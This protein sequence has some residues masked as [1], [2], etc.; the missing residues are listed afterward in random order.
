[1]NN[2]RGEFG[3]F[4]TAILWGLGFV[5]TALG[6]EAFSVIEVLAL[7]FW[8]ASIVLTL[9]FFKHLKKIDK[10]N[11]IYGFVL[12]SFLFFAFYFQTLGLTYT[13]TSKNAFLTSTN[14]VIVPLIGLLFYNR[15]LDI[16]NT[17]GALLTLLGI[18]FISYNP[19]FSINIGDMI[20]LFCAVLFAFHIFYTSEFN[21]R[22][23]NAT[24]MS[25]IQM[26]V[27]AMYSTI[28]LLFTDFSLGTFV[29]ELSFDTSLL[30]ILYSGVFSTAIC[31][32]LQTT[33][34]KYTSES[35]AAIILSTEAIFGAIFS[36][37]LL[38][39]ILPPTTIVGCIIVFCAVLFT[40]TKPN[41]FKTS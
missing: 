6:I 33:S 15:T 11:L 10:K 17:I 28:A 8:V 1:M 20:T 13:T 18:G 7:R 5:A 30:A 2:F 19:D 26:Y 32:Y 25:I 12:G 3:L 16:Y 37:I 40:E 23:G 41:L 38:N 34:Q 22:E 29:S 21:K 14:V 4:I 31:F 35:K 9:L 24:L 27:V 39:E 36:V